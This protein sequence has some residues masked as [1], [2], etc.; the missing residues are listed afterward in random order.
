ME[1]RAGLLMAYNKFS[2]VFICQSDVQHRPAFHIR[3]VQMSTEREMCCMES[4]PVTIC[5]APFS[6]YDFIIAPKELFV[7]SEKLIADNSQGLYQNLSR[8]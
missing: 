6:W 3:S 2:G 1:V 5:T 7:Q 8:I 4:F